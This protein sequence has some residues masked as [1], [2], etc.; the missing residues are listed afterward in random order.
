MSPGDPVS[1]RVT[2]EATATDDRGVTELRFLVDGNLVGTDA[3]APYSVNWDS[4]SVA[5]GSVALSAEADD[6]AGNTGVS[7]TV[8][9]MVDNVQPVSLADIQAEVFGPICS[10]CHSGPTGGSLPSGM[11]LSSANASHA[12]LVNVQSLQVALDRVE[13]GNPDDSYLVRKLEGG[14]D[15]SG[16]RM[17]QGGPFLDQATI[18]MIRQWITEGAENN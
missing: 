6:A 4:T 15:L 17:P 14:P 13:P 8:N 1:G 3:T 10:G 11:D 18:D 2:L 7:A 12:A 16:S 9:V 5:N